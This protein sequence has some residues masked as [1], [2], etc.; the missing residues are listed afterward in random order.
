MVRSGPASA[1]M[2]PV[3]RPGRLD[4]VIRYAANPESK[5]RMSDMSGMAKGQADRERG[6]GGAGWTKTGARAGR[7]RA[8]RRRTRTGH[9]RA[10]RRRRRLTATGASRAET[11]AGARRGASI[12]CQKTEPAQ[13]G[14]RAPPDPSETETAIARAGLLIGGRRGPGDGERRGAWRRPTRRDGE[15]DGDGR[16]RE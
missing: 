16:G 4:D 7:R 14:R 3:A 13:T 2:M 5:L 10:G 9:R 11:G 6:R 12:R 15:G 1:P 8:G